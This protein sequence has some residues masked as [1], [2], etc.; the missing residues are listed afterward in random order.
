M[1]LKDWTFQTQLKVCTIASSKDNESMCKQALWLA[2]A[3]AR[4]PNHH[5]HNAIKYYKQ[6]SN[7]HTVK[8]YY[9]GLHPWQS[10]GFS[11]MIQF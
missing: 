6:K 11:W 5:N 7:S 8:D 3:P 2:P 9:K 1:H 10:Q 4:T